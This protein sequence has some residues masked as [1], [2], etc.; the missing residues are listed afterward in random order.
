MSTDRRGGKRVSGAVRE[1]VGTAATRRESRSDV[2]TSRPPS[3]Q[4]QNHARKEP[5]S[6]AD[7]IKVVT[8]LL[9]EY[10]EHPYS[11]KAIKQAQLILNAPTISSRTI[12]DWI[13][14]YG[15]EVRSIIPAPPTNVEIIQAVYQDNMERWSKL[16]TTVLDAMLDPAKIAAAKFYELNAAAGTAKDKLDRN[17]GILPV[18]RDL[19]AQLTAIA[20]RV[21]ADPVHVLQAFIAS[22]D[23]R[24][25]PAITETVQNVETKLIT[26]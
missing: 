13:N 16:E 2:A 6:R 8:V 3:P 1:A 15:S 22:W 26:D 11:N 24:T 12:G 19:I 9:T 7:K 4:R 5:Y 21:G 23:E 10:A 17:R 20:S 25:Q 18:Y 14:E